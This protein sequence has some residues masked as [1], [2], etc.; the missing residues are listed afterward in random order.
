MYENKIASKL[1]IK[2]VNKAIPKMSH[3]RFLVHDHTND[4]KVLGGV[5]KKYSGKGLRSFSKRLNI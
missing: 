2:A 5:V 1:P 4:N 3:R